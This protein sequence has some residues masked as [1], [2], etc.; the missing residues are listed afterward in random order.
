LTHCTVAAT[1]KIPHIQYIDT[2][3]CRRSTQNPTHTVYWHTVLSP[4]HTKPH[5]YSI[6]THCTVAAAHKIPHTYS[7]LTHCTVTTA[8]KTP[9]IQ[10]IDT[11]YCRRS[12]Q[13]TWNTIKKS[14]IC[15]SQNRSSSSWRHLSIKKLCGIA[16]LTNVSTLFT[17]K[18]SRYKIRS[19]L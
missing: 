14:P 17:A 11:L 3:Y 16:T 7:I 13:I 2:L 5:T 19:N 1:H 10:Y 18:Q 6:L 12:T 4:Q 15:F 9:H 8:H